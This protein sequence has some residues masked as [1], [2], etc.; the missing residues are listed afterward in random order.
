MAGMDDRL[1][2]VIGASTQ[3]WTVNQ[4]FAGVW[5][6]LTPPTALCRPAVRLPPLL[7]GGRP[8][9]AGPPLAATGGG[10]YSLPDASRPMHV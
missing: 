6:M 9:L 7:V 2:R 10:Q 5:H 3:N 4:T 8:G 1:D